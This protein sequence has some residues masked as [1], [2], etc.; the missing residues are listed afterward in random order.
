VGQASDGEDVPGPGSAE[1]RRAVRHQAGN[2]RSGGAEASVT[3]RVMGILIKSLNLQSSHKVK[4][5]QV[6][7]V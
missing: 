6:V 1:A 2:V 7:K 3:P 5:N 4:A